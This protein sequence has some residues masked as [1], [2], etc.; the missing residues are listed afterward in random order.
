M[1]KIL[2]FFFI[3]VYFRKAAQKAIDKERKEKHR[4]LEV[5]REKVR[6]QLRDK[7]NLEKP[8]SVDEPEE[9]SD[10]SSSSSEEGDED[11]DEEDD[12]ESVDKEKVAREEAM[13]RLASM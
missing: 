8:E 13:E 1:D 10:S 12:C 7:Y 9:E 2:A 4:Q 6:Q 3:S 11:D 5:E